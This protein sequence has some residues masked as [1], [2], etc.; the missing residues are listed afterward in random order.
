[1]DVGEAIYRHLLKLALKFKTAVRLEHEVAEIIT[2][3]IINGFSLDVA[4]AEELIEVVS[5]AKDR[6]I[7]ELQAMFPPKVE[8]MKTPEFY[9]CDF[10]SA[11]RTL[12]SA[13]CS[14][15]AKECSAGP[16]RKRITPFNPG[17]GEQVARVLMEKY[18]WSPTKKTDSGKVSTAKD[19]LAVLPWPEAEAIT[20]YRIVTS[21]LTEAEKWI[22]GAQADGRVHGDV[23]TNGCVTG[24]MSH[25]DPNVNLPKVKKDKATGKPK[26]GRAGGFGF[27]CRRCFGARPGWWQVGA[28]ASSLEARM[29]ANR[30]FEYD[31][32]AYALIVLEGD[33]HTM[34]SN[35]LGIERDPS[36]T[37]F[38][39]FLYG[40]GDEKLG[41]SAGEKSQSKAKKRGAELRALF[42]KGIPALKKVLDDIQMQVR[43]RGYLIGLDGRHLPIRSTHAALN[44]QLQSD[45]AIVMK[46][47]LTIFFKRATAEIGPH[48]EK[49][50]LMANVHD[51]FQAE[52][53]TK[54]IAEQLGKIAVESIRQ[55]GVELGV[56]VRLDGEYKIGRNWAECH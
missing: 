22:E 36:K 1:V 5:T 9:V 11:R 52:A 19:V 46:K 35:I 18:G 39:A 47:A 43:Q 50:A 17:S 41:Y 25:S 15:G 48:G 34:N 32:G 24:R 20:E 27:E 21:R 45:G 10:C 8:E 51:E 6:I 56:K 13:K 29:L 31:D 2:L 53:A 28:D 3:Q 14:C 54:K 42:L 33:I 37:W 16:L 55:A 44:T 38:Y 7:E 4:A 26:L 49:W 40:A 30:M 12:K 23:N